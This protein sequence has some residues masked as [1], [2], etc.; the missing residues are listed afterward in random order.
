MAVEALV[1]PLNAASAGTISSYRERWTPRG[2]VVVDCPL[3]VHDVSRCGAPAFGGASG[4]ARSKCAKCPDAREGEL[5]APVLGRGRA[6]NS[7]EPGLLWRGRRCVCRTFIR[8]RPSL[9]LLRPLSRSRI[10]ASCI[11]RL[12]GR[13]QSRRRRDPRG[14]ITD[15]LEARQEMFRDS[16]NSFVVHQDHPSASDAFGRA[17]HALIEEHHSADLIKIVAKALR[18]LCGPVGN[19]SDLVHVDDDNIRDVGIELTSFLLEFLSRPAVVNGCA[20]N[21]VETAQLSFDLSS[22]VCCRPVPIEL[23][24]QRLPL[25]DTAQA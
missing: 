2:L 9:S 4:E 1:L 19:P 24:K 3:E 18:K 16:P 21:S 6:C 10:A 23:G 5:F 15:A 7:C 12:C 20:D 25:I 13:G 22:N 11:R 8:T 14:P 17:A